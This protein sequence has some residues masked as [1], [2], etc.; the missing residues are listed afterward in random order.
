[1]TKAELKEVIDT[2]TRVA[3]QAVNACQALTKATKEA[4]RALTAFG[5]ATVEYS[6]RCQEKEIRRGD[7]P[8]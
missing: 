2:C 8:N 4:G 1:M 5:D 3:N 7:E 6:L